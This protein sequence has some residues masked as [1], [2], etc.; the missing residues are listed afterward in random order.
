MYAPPPFRCTDAAL[1]ARLMRE[2]PLASLV[3]NGPDGLPL[4]THLPLQLQVH[5]AAPPQPQARQTPPEGGPAFVLHGHMARANPHW[6]WLARQPRALAVFMGP[7]A[8]MSPAVY[9]D[10]E[11]VPTWNYLAVHCTVQARLLEGE[12]A[13]DA[14]LKRLIASHERP[15][16]AQWRSLPERYTRQMLAGIAA[17]QLDV[18]HWQ[19][20][21]KLNQHRP[22]AHDAMHAAYAGGAPEARA[23]AAWMRTLRMAPGHAGDSQA[24]QGATES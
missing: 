4:V 19:C 5:E 2:H 22:E 8:Y 3:S 6:R 10:R 7:H 11:R 23:L 12:A 18:T 20:T 1:A 17:F 24:D 13:K 21:F 9:P 14:L 15:Y 16:A